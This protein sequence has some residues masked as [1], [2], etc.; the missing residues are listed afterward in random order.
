MTTT[1]PLHTLLRRLAILACLVFAGVL[2]AQH[3]LAFE[4]P[5]F[6]GD[7]LD[8]AGLLAEADRAALRE[9]IRSM[10]ETDD[11]WA[12]V[13]V[14]RDLQQAS[15]EEA[16]VSV[17]EKWKLGQKGKDNGVLVVI[18]PAARKMRIE[19]GY[20]LEGV[21][22]DALSRRIIDDVFAPAFR[23]K[24]YMDGLIQGFEVMA[25]TRRGEK[26]FPEPPPAP[27]QEDIDW[28]GAG[29]RFFLAVLANLLPVGFYAGALRYGR[30]RR[31]VR[32]SENDEDI[33]SPF[34]IFL[35]FGIFFGLFY[36]VFGA[37]F[38]DQPEVMFG[39]MGGNALFAGVFGIAYVVKAVRFLTGVP[40]SGGRRRSSSAKSGSSQDDRRQSSAFSSS[41]SSSSDSGSSSSSSDGGS[42]G[43]GGSSGDW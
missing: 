39:L 9:R 26:A 41:S 24:R 20:G 11:I 21:L 42:S 34:F 35:F 19:V 7:V 22:T 5:R 37:A 25:Q 36:A 30:Q 14:A 12:A 4:S 13:Y 17:F 3:V 23:E 32:K 38:P 8:E 15:I 33:R 16:A 43:G 18:V 27:D 10:R 2:G 31:R 40:K 6:Q 1:H 28:D 29:T